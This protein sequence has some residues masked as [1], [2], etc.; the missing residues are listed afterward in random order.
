MMEVVMQNVAEKIREV[1]QDGAAV[2]R[3][4]R[5]DVV[6]IYD[7]T[8]ADPSRSIPFDQAVADMKAQFKARHG[9]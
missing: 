2:E 6:K 3:W 9:I 4:L 1:E 7:A 5:E 8:I